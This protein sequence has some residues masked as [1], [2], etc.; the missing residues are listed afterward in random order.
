MYRQLSVTLSVPGLKTH[1]GIGCSKQ[2]EGR[3][4]EAV[5][6]DRLVLSP[7]QSYQVPES[8]IYLVVVC[9]DRQKL[10]ANE[11]QA[12]VC[13]CV[14]V[15]VCTLRGGTYQNSH[16]YYIRLLKELCVHSG[17]CLKQHSSVPSIVVT[18]LL[19]HQRQA[20]NAKSE[21]VGSL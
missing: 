20:C 8:S 21:K 12:C 19:W 14:C 7:F 16:L 5:K 15:C 4:L 6:Q 9:G 11:R 10:R 2:S 18:E 3:Q 13:V 1:P 17:P